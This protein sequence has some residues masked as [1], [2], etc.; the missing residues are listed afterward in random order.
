MKAGN[1]TK[2]VVLLGLAALVAASCLARATRRAQASGGEAGDEVA[3][4]IDS[5]LYA[6][7]EFFGAQ[8][9][10]PYPTPEARNRLAELKE[11]RPNEPRVLLALARLDEK[12]GRYEQAE[13]G[14]GEYVAASGESFK[15]L[16][17]LAAFQHGRA[18]FEKEAATLE[19]MLGAAP[20]GGR[21]EV[22]ERL[23]RLAEAQRLEKYLRPE[24]FER[25][26]SE[27]SSDFEIVKGYVER[28]SERKDTAA[29][30]DAVRRHARL[31]PSRRRYF[32]EKEVAILDAAGRGR[33]AEAVYRAAF[34]PFWPSDLS[35]QFYDFLREHDR[36]R[37]YGTELREAFRRDPS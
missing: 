14:M 37:A 24:F 32:L 6:R 33:E 35:E 15:A 21:R 29:A 23:V 20:A 10:V 13:A 4:Q 16:E 9:R 36:F 34:D 30:L 1:K 17:A 26:I 3:A 7:A 2:R 11:Q 22:L 25:V 5:A 12:L 31:F 28:L 18:L 19:R 27:H 8:A